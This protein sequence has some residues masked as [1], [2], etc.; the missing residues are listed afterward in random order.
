MQHQEM[1]VSK[2]R[3]LAASFAAALTT[4]FAT[5]AAMAAGNNLESYLFRFDFSKGANEFSSSSNYADFNFVGANTAPTNGPNGASSAATTTNSARKAFSSATVL[6][7][8]WTIATSLSPA[9]VDNAVVR[10]RNARRPDG[11]GGA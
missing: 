11:R 9:A 6:S 7:N 2:L 8:S 5:S 1:N 3:R 4:M 10:A